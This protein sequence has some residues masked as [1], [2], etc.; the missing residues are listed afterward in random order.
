MKIVGTI[1]RLRINEERK[2]VEMILQTA[3]ETPNYLIIT[4][5]IR[6]GRSFPPS[7]NGDMVVIEASLKGRRWTDP[8]SGEVR[9]FMSLN[10]S[11][12]INLEGDQNEN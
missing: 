6:E 4:Y 5:F 7:K 2:I 8:D 12:I 1:E 10:A 3:E 9:Y 11:K